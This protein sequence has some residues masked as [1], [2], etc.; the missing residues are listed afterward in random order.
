MLPARATKFN[1]PTKKLLEFLLAL[2]AQEEKYYKT[3]IFPNTIR[4]TPVRVIY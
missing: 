2:F 3:E 4:K 1:K